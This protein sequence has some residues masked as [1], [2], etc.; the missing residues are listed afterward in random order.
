MSEPR[1]SDARAVVL[2]GG[3]PVGRAWQTG[4]IA[5]LK[6]LGIDI[7]QADFIVGTSA[8][9]IVGAEVALGRDMHTALPAAVVPAT[10]P[11][12]PPVG[13]G[14]VMAQISRAVLSADPEAGLR[15]VGQLALRASV[16]AEERA[17][18]RPNIQGVIGQSWPT[19]LH[20]AAVS[21]TT[22]ALKVWDETSG[23][24]LQQA[25]AASS[26]LP[27]VWPPI[28][29]AGDRY[30][31]GGV[32]STL[33]ADVAAGN[34]R[35][36]VICCHPLEGPHADPRSVVPLR[37][38]EL[39]RTGGS[40]VE[41]IVPNQDFLNMTFDVTSLLNPALERPAFEIGKSQA[42]EQ[43]ERFRAVWG[44]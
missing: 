25:L 21:T 18:N 27:G 26:A 15:E 3:G 32:R 28:T 33:N 23:V 43:I 35:V 5:G 12:T 24:T 10:G 20:V 36:L 31:D 41:V 1:E 39:L 9:A 11:T 22:G 34:G 6:D 30:M 7:A 44:E 8:G 4:L 37:E 38:I 19:N 42:R 14:E 13:V 40:V 29:V 17:L 2:G 16:P